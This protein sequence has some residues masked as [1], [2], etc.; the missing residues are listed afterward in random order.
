MKIA[1][2][3][4]CTISSGIYT[5]AISRETGFRVDHYSDPM[6]FLATR[7]NRRYDFIITEF[8]FENGNL[9]RYWKYLE[10]QKMIVISGQKIKSELR[11]PVFLKDAHAKNNV[12]SMIKM[13]LPC[14]SL[15]NAD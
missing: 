3:D 1:I 6:E 13:T 15:V 11:C 7:G 8:Y 5:V 4:E 2:I 12:V 9:D 10:G 14:L